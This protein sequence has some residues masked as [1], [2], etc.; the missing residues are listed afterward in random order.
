MR[1]FAIAFFV[2]FFAL[3]CRNPDPRDREGR[4]IFRIGYMPNLTHAP[5]L[6]GLEVGMFSERLGPKVAVESLPFT[7]G[8]SVIEALFA[9]EL[10]VAYVGPNPAINAFFVS[11]GRAIRI[12]SG[13]TS[14]GAQ[15]VV[16]E[17]IAGPAN[18]LGRRVASPALA[19][20]QDVSLR[21][22]L[23]DQGIPVG[24]GPEDVG[25]I[26][27]SPSDVLRLF[28]QGQIAGAWVPEP[29]ASRMVLDAGAALLVDER[30]LW[31]GGRFPTTVIV[32]S[33][34]ALEIR[35][36]L[37]RRFLEGH[38]DAV[39]NLASSPLP[40]RSAVSR[41]LR[42]ALGYSLPAEVLDRAY[43]NLE[44][45]MDPMVPQMHEMALRAF[46]LGYLHSTEGLDSA[47]D[48]SLLP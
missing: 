34:K 14:G 13:C 45:T 40:S 32:A 3:G 1:A 46:R 29:W 4:Q 24:S 30:D 26:P 20:T 37:V 15:L 22:W 17:G 18:L 7:A 41:K 48:V 25:V 9:G 42:E 11:R 6:L 33:A 28:Q 36:E 44:F 16:E 35:R 47:F 19:N 5:A 23:Q 43:S 10:D 12:V 27:I 8:P 38:S 2:T 21:I 31:P 39:E